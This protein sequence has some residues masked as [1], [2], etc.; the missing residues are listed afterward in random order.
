MGTPHYMEIVRLMKLKGLYSPLPFNTNSLLILC[1]DYRVKMSSQDLLW[2]CLDL[3]H[4]E[5]SAGM[6]VALSHKSRPSTYKN[7]VTFARVFVI[8]DKMC[9]NVIIHLGRVDLSSS[10]N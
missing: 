5:L 2:R 8:P 1:N 10:E 6:L 4:G 3:R 9:L 7:D